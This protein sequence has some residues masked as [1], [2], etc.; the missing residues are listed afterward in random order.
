MAVRRRL[1]E[2]TLLLTFAQLLALAVGFVATVV[3]ARALGPEGRGLYAWLLTL[4][5]IAIQLAAL[6]STQTVRAIAG[7]FGGE[8]GFVATLVALSI[9]GSLLGLPLLT[10]AWR[11]L[12]AGL[13]PTL[14]AVA[15]AAVPLSAAAV[16]L[17]SL[18]HIQERSWPILCGHLGPRVG[19]LLGVG[20]LWAAGR[21]DLATAIWLNTAAA[22]VQFAVLIAL[23]PGRHRL[24]PRLALAR[25][26]ARLLGPGWAG[27]LAVFVMP[28]APLVMLAGSGMVPEAGHYS[29][30]IALFEIMTVL[31]VAASG[32]LTSHLVDAPGARPGLRGIMGLAGLMA[33]G[34]GVALL[35]APVLVPLLF[36]AAFRPAVG[37]FQAL[38]VAVMLATVY[39]FCQGILHARGRPAHILGPP[40]LALLTAGPIS[41][42]AIPTIGL[43]GAVLATVCG[44]AVLAG[45]AVW[46]AFRH[47]RPASASV[48]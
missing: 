20:A 30:A 42:M 15:W 40:L 1:V 44:F 29:I 25:S 4:T 24:R 34:C 5:A 7:E 13:D 36:G 19:L 48:G 22:A 8:P 45:V 46:L 33:A 41:F 2:R 6:A 31:P 27:S 26:V 14:L 11:G 10:Y 39:Q 32:V 43:Y 21:L 47:P 37:A 18:V 12:P 38:L 16:S 17:I 3:I 28:R 23:V 9:L 35:A